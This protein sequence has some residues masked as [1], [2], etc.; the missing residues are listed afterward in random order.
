MKYI[1]T[2]AIINPAV[3]FPKE[4]SNDSRWCNANPEPIPIRA[5]KTELK[6]FTYFEW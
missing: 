2:Y 3:I 1:N 4:N 5:N 6:T